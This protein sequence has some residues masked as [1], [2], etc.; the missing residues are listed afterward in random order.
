MRPAPAIPTASTFSWIV[1]AAVFVSLT[2][3]SVAASQVATRDA[4]VGTSAGARTFGS[5]QQAAGALVAAAEQFDAGRLIE[6]FGPDGEDVVL[7]GE[8]AQ[9]RQRATDFAAK[10]REKMSVSLDPKSRN[11]AFLIVGNEDWPFPI[12]IVKRGGAW[13]FDAAAGKQE[14]RAR[15]AAGVDVGG[16]ELVA[17]EPFDRDRE[18]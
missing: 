10:A 17:R 7:T 2:V 1:G 8:Y 5:P 3:V 13:S 11:R 4:S 9:D 18:V 15:R 14:L 6:L 16:V 12:P